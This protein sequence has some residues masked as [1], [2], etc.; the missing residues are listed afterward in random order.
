MFRA[1]S[2]IWWLLALCGIIEAMNA[3]LNLLMLN[4]LQI[5][6]SAQIRAAEHGL[7][8]ERARLRGVSL[9]DQRRHLEFRQG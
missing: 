6:Q 5:T 2:K 7:G 1:L 4:S 3:M 9:R 8:Y